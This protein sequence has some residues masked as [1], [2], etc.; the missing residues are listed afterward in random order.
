[1]A[2]MFKSPKMPAP[3]PPTRMPSQMDQEMIAAGR[4]TRSAA[5]AR[6]GRLSTILTDTLGDTSGAYSGRALGVAA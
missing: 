4:R 2:S 1:M 5:L 6:K 3:P